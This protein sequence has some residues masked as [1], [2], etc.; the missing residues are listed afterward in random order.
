MVSGRVAGEGAG[1]FANG[2]ADG[3]A[4]AGAAQEVRGVAGYESPYPYLDRL[5]PKM[6]E[7][8]A[9]RVPATGRFCGYCYARLRAEDAVCPFCGT[10]TAE[11][12]TVTE[13]PQEVLRLYLIK[14]KTEARWVHG[15]AFFGL[16][17]ASALFLWMVIWGPGLLGHP[18]LAFAVL[19]LG[20]YVLAQ[21]FG[22]LI[23]AQIGYRKGARK[24]DELWTAYLAARDGASQASAP[25]RA[26]S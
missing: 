10:A 3:D 15:G 19:L 2:V 8:L 23:G 20:G 1:W 13:I 16:I 24:R 4:K 25:S 7:R 21:L 18:A 5:Q 6:E 14:Q 11:R 12:P 17:L 9:R 22:T 26:S